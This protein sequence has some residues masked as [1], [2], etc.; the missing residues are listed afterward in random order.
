MPAR[1]PAAHQ[2]GYRLCI[3][4]P[5]QHSISPT[6][7]RLCEHIGGNYCG[8]G[9]DQHHE[10]VAEPSMLSRQHYAELAGDSSGP[11]ARNR[12][13]RRNLTCPDGFPHCERSDGSKETGKGGKERRHLYF[14]RLYG[15]RGGGRS[16]HDV[17]AKFAKEYRTPALSASASKH[18]G[19]SFRHRL[20]TTTFHASSGSTVKVIGFERLQR[21]QVSVCGVTMAVTGRSRTR[22]FR[23]SCTGPEPG[24]ARP[25]SSG[26][27]SSNT[28]MLG[29]ASARDA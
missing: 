17:A 2:V 20:S 29:C 6:P 7:K 14:L 21:S 4:S 3:S 22:P 18:D 23:T 24:W 27:R 13:G 19:H 15:L 12:P 11:E 1:A 25:P 5:S 16:D 8:C 28:S 9:A 26:H 10:D